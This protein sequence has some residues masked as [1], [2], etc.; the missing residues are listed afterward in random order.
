MSLKARFALVCS[1]LVGLAAVLDADTLVL[2]NGGRV[3]GELVAV[4]NG[5]VEFEERRGGFGGGGGRTIRVNRDE[6]VS[7]ELDGRGYPGDGYP[8]GGG[9]YPGGGGGYPGGGGRPPGMRERVVSV[10]AVQQW[11]DTGVMVRPGQ[12][13]FFESSGQ[14]RWGPGRRDGP[15]GEN[16]SPHNGARPIP[17]RPAAALIGSVG[18]GDDIFFIG[19]DRGGIRMRSGGRLLLGIN[20]DGLQDNSGNFRVTI[21]Y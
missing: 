20:D 19:A 7:I 3:T 4:R 11:S 13:V 10:S 8:G 5:I 18:D 21:Y 6:V 1:L 17:N 2:R 16:K 14:V 9:G 12:T 15:E